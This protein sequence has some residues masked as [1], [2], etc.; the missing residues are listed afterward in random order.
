MLELKYVKVSSEQKIG[1]MDIESQS[2]GAFTRP[3]YEVV[4]PVALITVSLTGF[5]EL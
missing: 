3:L 5:L 1:H 4:A 2:E